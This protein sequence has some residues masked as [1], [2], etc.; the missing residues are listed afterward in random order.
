MSRDEMH[1]GI[2]GSMMTSWSI[3]RA[4]LRGKEEKGDDERRGVFDFRF[5]SFTGLEECYSC[6]GSP[7]T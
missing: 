2:K 1:N 7:T 6:T 4:S 3:G 5:A